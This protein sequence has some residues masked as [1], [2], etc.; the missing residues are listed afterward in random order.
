MTTSSDLKKLQS[1][2]FGPQQ[3]RLDTLAA[4]LNDPEQRADDVADV[5][6]D[7]LQRTPN[8]ENLSRVISE[9]T[10]EAIRLSIQ[11]DSKHVAGILYPAVLPAIRKSIEQTMQNFMEGIDLLVKQQ[12]SIDSLKWRFESLRTGVP[13]HEIMLRNLLRY[14][15]EQLFLIHRE[16]GLLIEHVSCSEEIGR[17][18]DAVSAMLT[19]I[20]SFVRESFADENDADD[21]LDRVTVGD[22]IVYLEHG[23]HAIVASVVRGVA[24]PAY[25]EKL[26]QINEEVHAAY[27]RQLRYFS[28]REGDIDGLKNLLSQG[29]AREFQVQEK[30]S[31]E[32]KA[33]RLKM[34]GGSMAAA[35]LLVAGYLAWGAW[36]KS[37]VNRLMDQLT[38][39]DGIV[40]TR[41]DKHNGRWRI[42]GLRDPAAIPPDDIVTRLGLDDD[43]QLQFEPYLSLSPAVVI[44]RARK[45]LNIP[46]T[47]TSEL[48]GET[49]R[50]S[51]PA[52]LDWYLSLPRTGGLPPGSARLDPSGLELDP[53]EVRAL[54]AARLPG[55]E[56]VEIH[57][58]TQG[59]LE[60]R[61]GSDVA[62]EKAAAIERLATMLAPRAKI[63]ISG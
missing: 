8:K 3:E 39:R 53:D 57:R 12:F 23:P 22:R 27:S 13:F 54:L 58:N 45:K 43:V 21:R 17:D 7:A 47:V 33:R 60:I 50:L 38:Q 44:E 62:A 52:P 48:E 10:T 35:L 63:I 28:G 4:R 42:S 59:I 16:S 2:L 5:I 51:G 1:L 56:P 55:I 30:R 20:E 11:R 24:T 46:A 61:I 6:V 9:P 18:Q 32:Q 40:T 49:L 26:K 37:R 14:Q 15:V 34:L 29:L 19:A 36:E 41:L 25:R 31:E